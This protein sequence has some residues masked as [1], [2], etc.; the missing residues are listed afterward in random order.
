MRVLAAL[1]CALLLSGCVTGT[2]AHPPTRQSPRSDVPPS[3]PAPSTTGSTLPTGHYTFLNTTG[4]GSPVRWSTCD[5]IAY[6]VRP[7]GAPP[8]A[9]NLLDQSIGIVAEASGLDFVRHGTTSEDPSEERRLYQPKRYG[10]QWA[11]VLIAFSDPAE[12]PPLSGSQAG[13]GGAAYVDSGRV[14]PRYVTGTVVFDAPQLNRF[15]SEERVQAVMVHELAHLVGLGHVNDPSQLMHKVQRPGDATR[16]QEGDRAGLEALG[17]GPCLQ[18]LDP[19]R[20]AR[21]LD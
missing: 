13:Y 6:V 16:L 15:R 11:P 17:A 5:P 14:P 10:Q 20:V 18:P 7:E 21:A 4:D 2:N 12:F 1:M 3:T 8:G 19:A 9:R